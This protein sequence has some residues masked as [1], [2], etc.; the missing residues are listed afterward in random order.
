MTKKK[1][2]QLVAREAKVELESKSKPGPIKEGIKGGKVV[3][4]ILVLLLVAVEVV[5]WSVI[6]W[7]GSDYRSRDLW[8]FSATV[9]SWEDSG[10][11]TSVD[12][13]DVVNSDNRILD[14]SG[15]LILEGDQSYQ[16][17]VGKRYS[18]LLEK[19]SQYR[20]IWAKELDEDYGK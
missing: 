10:D 4:G 13:A 12:F 3:L 11:S 6:L 16:L 5:V 2:G 18:I 8:I 19:Q 15:G 9:E 1:S 7:G 14:F 20:L 17:E